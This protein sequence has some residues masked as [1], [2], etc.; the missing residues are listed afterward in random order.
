MAIGSLMGGLT[1]QKYGRKQTHLIICL[2][3]WIGWI[4][5]YYAFNLE[6]L[7]VGR[8]LT[9]LSSGMIGP[10]TG[11]YIGETSEPKY[12]VVLLG[13]L[14][15]AVTS[16]VL[17]SHLLGTYLS[18]QTTALII[19][20]L[21]LISYI[22][23][24][25]TPESPAWLAQNGL[26]EEARQAFYWLRGVSDESSKELEQILAKYKERNQE[27]VLRNF[28]SYLQE[29][30]N[31]EFW[32]PMVVLLVFFITSQWAGVNAVN[33]YSVTLMK[34]TL[35]DSMD[36]YLATFII[37]CIRLVASIV[38]C[39]LVR[40][41]GRRPLALVGGLGTFLPLF[42]LS[43]FIHFSPQLPLNTTDLLAVPLTCLLT[44]VFFVTAGFVTLPWTL[45]G[46]LL[47]LS[48]RSTGSG[49]AS[50]IAY[51]S[52]FTVVKVM[53]QMFDN[54]GVDGTFLVYGCM[55]FCGTIFVYLCLPETKGKTLFEIEEHYRQN[56]AVDLKL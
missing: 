37:D 17:V 45:L 14:S 26:I 21:P 20:S 13:G 32:K 33:F 51:L 36:E 31:P 11:V 1:I 34:E 44:Y 18:W 40:N 43:A 28:K 29:L 10:A 9:G 54:L 22:L 56:H 42:V 46:E 50:G 30:L 2:P 38:A 6:M 35:G 25:F 4:L 8:F 49:I 23:M 19:S 48:K 12:R 52:I 3:F 27:E 53:P 47:P 5:I 39:F 24:I 16:G 7:L 15:L 55:A 41:I